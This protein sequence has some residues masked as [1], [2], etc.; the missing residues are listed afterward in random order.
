M[1]WPFYRDRVQRLATATSDVFRRHASK[2][3]ALLGV[4]VAVFGVLSLSSTP[5]A[6]TFD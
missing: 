5:Q 6:G 3:D 4:V 2:L 1:P